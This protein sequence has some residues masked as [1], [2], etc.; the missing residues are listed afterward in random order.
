MKVPRTGWSCVCV[1]KLTESFHVADSGMQLWRGF[2]FLRVKDAQLTFFSARMGNS[3]HGKGQCFVLLWCSLFKIFPTSFCILK[4]C[5]ELLFLSCLV[6]EWNLQVATGQITLQSSWYKCHSLLP[7][8]KERLRSL[9]Y[10]MPH[11]SSGG[12]D[13]S[14]LFYTEGA[15]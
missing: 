8:C 1:M 12:N 3:I 4:T 10:L 13:Y 5:K 9:F 2:R 7:P 11:A 15:S 14:L 6:A